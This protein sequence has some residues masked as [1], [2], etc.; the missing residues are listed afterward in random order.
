MT[1]KKKYLLSAKEIIIFI[2]VTVFILFLPYLLSLP[3]F[4]FNLNDEG[5][6]QIGTAI[7][8]MTAPFIGIAGSI[9][10]YVA[11]KSQYIANQ[12]I[13]EQ[14]QK[15]ND[16]QLFFKLMDGLYDRFKN[17]VIENDDRE[18]IHG[19]EIQKF[20]IQILKK[21]FKTNQS[22]F[23]KFIV[24]MAHEKVNDSFYQRLIKD[25]KL[26]LINSDIIDIPSFKQVMKNAQPIEKQKLIDS[27]S[28]LNYPFSTVFSDI[29]QEHFYDVEFK[30]RKPIYE[31]AY[32]EIFGRYGGL[33]ESYFSSLEYLI[34][35]VMEKQNEFYLTFLKSNLTSY[36]H[37]LL[38]Y[39]CASHKSN[40]AF[41][42]LVFETELLYSLYDDRNLLY[43]IKDE[44][45][46]KSEIDLILN[47][48]EENN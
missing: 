32:S 28:F 21:S 30:I 23:G 25:G 38:Y 13:K 1:K 3:S 48:D 5:L 4:W 24:M 44:I 11:F 47:Y 8:G 26:G 31:K 37:A 22:K 40:A 20:F 46:L 43:N 15:Q 19:L 34:T 35:F 6:A 39:Y 42:K 16:D 33:L 9:L 17:S 36:E 10:V 45:E 29:A 18:Q 7:S 27:S 14:F 41:R 2:V 12:E